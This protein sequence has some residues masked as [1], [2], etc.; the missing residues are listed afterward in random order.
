M[1]LLSYWWLLSLNN[2]SFAFCVC[3]L[4]TFCQPEEVF[5]TERAHP[6]DGIHHHSCV[7]FHFLTLPVQL[8]FSLPRKKKKMIISLGFGTVLTDLL[9]YFE[10]KPVV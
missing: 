10:F 6:D 1:L 7:L 9:L 8:M 2:P 5:V 4:V 3:C